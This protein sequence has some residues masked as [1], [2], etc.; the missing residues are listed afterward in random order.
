VP[1]RAA[2]VIAAFAASAALAL[3]FASAS[4]ADACVNATG[5][6]GG[7]TTFQYCGG[8][9]SITVPA[10]TTQLLVTA[11]GAKG[12]DGFSRTGG[13]GGKISSTVTL[14]DSDTSTTLYVEVGGT[15]G[16]NGGGAG[17][18]V[19][20]GASDVRLISCAADCATGGD[21]TSLASRLLAAA[22][23]GGV[24]GCPNGGAGGSGSSGEGSDGGYGPCGYTQDYAGKGATQD[25]AGAGGSANQGG[26]DGNAG[27]LGRG[28]TPGFSCGGGGGGGWYGGGGGA[29]C[30]P[31]GGGSSRGPAG[32][33]SYLGATSDAAAV[34]V[35]LVEATSTALSSSANP[36]TYGHAVTFTA[37]VSATNTPDGGTVQF[38]DGGTPLGDP[39]DVDSAT[40]TA[41]ITTS[42]LAAG[43]HSITASYTGHGGFGGSNS[44]AVS[45]VVDKAGTTTGLV[46]SANP[47]ARGGSVTFT[48]T[49]SPG[50]GDHPSGTVTFKDGSTV[51]GTDSVASDGTASVV[52]SA[53]SVG[54]HSVTASYGGDD[55]FAGSDSSAVSQVVDKTSTSTAVASSANPSHR[56]QPVTFTATVSAGAG[57]HPTGTVTF[58]DG[59]TALGTQPVA[60]DGTAALATNDLSTGTHSITATYSGDQDFGGSDSPVL[61]DTVAKRTSSTSVTCSPASL[62]TG[63]SSTCTAS[64]VDSDTGT[65]STPQGTVTFTTDGSGAFAPSSCTLSAGGTPSCSASYTPSAAGDGSHKVTATYSGDADHAVSSGQA[66]VAVADAQPAAPGQPSQPTPPA[67]PGEAP[68]APKLVLSGTH[69]K[70]KRG[71][72]TITLRC[73]GAKSTVCKGDVWFQVARLGRHRHGKVGKHISVSLGAGHKRVYRLSVPSV[74]RKHLGRS[75]TTGAILRIAVT[76]GNATGRIA[77][78]LHR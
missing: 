45:Q 56:G 70:V 22:G 32:N 24:G 55:N 41:Q 3:T 10:H 23:G 44:S 26:T 43:S 2:G 19:G 51:I 18:A 1:E 9:Q 52:T 63:A 76:A 66:A 73:A 37:T 53:L 34:S 77:I 64:V 17:N 21:S 30:A 14:A 42:A 4:R 62:T 40:G 12:A 36:S 78:E 33:T 71:R 20:G 8:E 16:W 72:G 25:A 61:S 46:S 50:A 11:I 38:Y 7:A 65:G 35:T 74:L 68:A 31:G 60:G 47:S 15:N 5:S 29:N 27:S 67:G 59:A 28:G 49:V 57:D 75:R 58:Y 69:I 48:A 6:G 54:T 39:Q 13:S